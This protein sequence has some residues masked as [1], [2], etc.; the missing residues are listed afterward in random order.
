[1]TLS[2]LSTAQW[3]L[4]AWLLLIF[5]LCIIPTDRL[6]RVSWDM[7][8]PDKFI[9]AAL[10]I[11]YGLLAIRAYPVAQGQ[12]SARMVVYIIGFAIVYSFF[13]ETYQQYCTTNRRFELPDIIA[14]TVGACIAICIAW[15]QQKK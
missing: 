7:L 13:L 14:N 9:H 11:V 6:P 5:L 1:M 10:F 12:L 4:A 2:R 3:A 15:W 8:E